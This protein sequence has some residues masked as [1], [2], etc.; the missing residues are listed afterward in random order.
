MHGYLTI[1]EF[2]LGPDI[3]CHP[4]NNITKSWKELWKKPETIIEFYVL[5]FGFILTYF[6]DLRCYLWNIW[7]NLLGTR[8]LRELCGGTCF[9]MRKCMLAWS[10]PQSKTYSF[11]AKQ[12]NATWNYHQRIINWTELSFSW[13][14]VLMLCFSPCKCVQTAVLQTVLKFAAYQ[15]EQDNSELPSNGRNPVSISLIN[16]NDDISSIK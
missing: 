12:A 14:T 7:N 16:V 8:A 5:L 9:I 10:I 15:K 13:K 2:R 3:A 6:G 11:L 1:P 4:V